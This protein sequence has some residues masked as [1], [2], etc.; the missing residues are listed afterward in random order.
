MAHN[1]ADFIFVN[2]AVS[3]KVEHFEGDVEL[4]FF[5]AHHQF[6]E[7][8]EKFVVVDTLVAVGVELLYEAV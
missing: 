3:V 5:G 8:R 7:K 4:L 6:N 1:C 2:F